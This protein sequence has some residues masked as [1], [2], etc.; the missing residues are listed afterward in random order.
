MFFT[1]LAPHT[2]LHDNTLDERQKIKIFRGHNS[3][4]AN[5]L[6]EMYF[7]NVKCTESATIANELTNYFSNIGE[8]LHTLFAKSAVAEAKTKNSSNVTA[9][10][11]EAFEFHKFK[12][13]EVSDAEVSEVLN[14]LK[15]RKNGGIN[16]IPAFIYKLLEPLILYPLTHIINQ[17]IKTCSFPDVWKKSIGHSHP[18]RRQ[19]HSTKQLSSDI[20]PTNI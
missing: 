7:D 16:Q 9:E 18:K 4:Q 3:V 11:F 6:L 19:Y 2:I 13:T 8:K 20:P 17:S 1:H 14:S 12:I 10:V 5:K 15:S